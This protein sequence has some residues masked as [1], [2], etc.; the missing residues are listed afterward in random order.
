MKQA[1]RLVL[2]LLTLSFFFACK[3]KTT[4]SND[5]PPATPSLEDVQ[6][7]APENAPDEVQ[8]YVDLAN[9]Y[10]G[11]G[12]GF[13]SYTSGESD[14]DNG[15]W[16][17]SYTNGQLTLYVTAEDNG[18]GTVTWKWIWDGTDSYGQVYDQWVFLNGT[19]D[20]EGKNGQWTMYYTNSVQAVIAAEW[21]TTAGG[22]KN[23]EVN[24]FEEDGTEILRY[25][26]VS[27]PDNSGSFSYF[28]EYEGSMILAL[29]ATW[30]AAGAGS[31]TT[32]DTDGTVVSTV[33]WQ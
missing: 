20:K 18:D 19:Y 1:L 25:V 32:Y 28:Y 24:Y 3:E 15:V 9:G 30:N 22:V 21:S 33:T 6:I 4:S 8:T 23:L 14:Y 26:V 31:Y 11:L 27:N 2:I 29:Q 5:D 7:E 10:M 16:T 12:Y 13:G 17:W